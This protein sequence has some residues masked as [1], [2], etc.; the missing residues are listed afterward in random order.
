MSK[1]NLQCW[2]F[3]LNYLMHH[4]TVSN[5]DLWLKSCVEQILSHDFLLL[6]FYIICTSCQQLLWIL[7]VWM[8]VKQAASSSL[9]SCNIFRSIQRILFK[10]WRLTV[11]Y[12]L[13]TKC[14][15]TLFYSCHK[16]MNRFDKIVFHTKMTKYFIAKPL[17]GTANF[18]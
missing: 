6:C 4:Y 16:F 14:H 13:G 1:E 8:M 11:L 12:L 9:K 7:Q 17:F 10:L 3:D 2:V 18:F 5:I 15:C